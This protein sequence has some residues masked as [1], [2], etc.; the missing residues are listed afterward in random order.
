MKRRIAPLL[1]LLCLVLSLTGCDLLTPPRSSA[2]AG[3]HGFCSGRLSLY[4]GKL[5][6]YLRELKSFIKK[7]APHS[8]LSPYT[9]HQGESQ[10]KTACPVPLSSF[11]II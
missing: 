4:G 9:F 2:P 7:S 6:V 11:L 8:A 1:A 10:G 3:R 5:R